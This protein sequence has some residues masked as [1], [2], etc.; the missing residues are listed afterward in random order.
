MRIQLFEQFVNEAER[1]TKI[2]RVHD[3]FEE[4]F[5]NQQFVKDMFG[6]NPDYDLDNDTKQSPSGLLKTVW[7]E[8][9]N[10]NDE[11]VKALDKDYKTFAKPFE[12]WAK[13]NNLSDP[14]ITTSDDTINFQITLY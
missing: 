2:E 8:I 5:L 11:A 14:E 6:E 7:I 1:R 12:E 13:K 3:L 4:D 9:K 10:P